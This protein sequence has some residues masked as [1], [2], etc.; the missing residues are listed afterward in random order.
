MIS[1]GVFAILHYQMDKVVAYPGIGLSCACDE[2][3][4][5]GVKAFLLCFDWVVVAHC[6]RAPCCHTDHSGVRLE[7]ALPCY[8]NIFGTRCLVFLWVSIQRAVNGRG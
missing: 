1:A 2:I 8:G 4:K 5:D 7:I 6:H 3:G